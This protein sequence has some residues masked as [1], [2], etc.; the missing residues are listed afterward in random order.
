MVGAL[1]VYSPVLAAG[2]CAL[3]FLFCLVATKPQIAPWLGAAAGGVYFGF[4]LNIQADAGSLPISPLDAVPALLLFSALRLRTSREEPRQ[5]SATQTW[6]W[7]AFAFLA[8]GLTLGSIIGH[9][10]GTDEYPYL[11]VV[12]IEVSLLVVLLAALYAGRYP[13]WARAVTAGFWF[14]GILAALESLATFGA[15]SVLGR[16]PWDLMGIGPTPLPFEAAV[17][18]DTLGSA[19]DNYLPTFVM[20]PALALCLIRLRRR[21]V[22]LATL[23]LVA[24]ALSLSRAMWFATALTIGLTGLSRLRTHYSLR[25]LVRLATVL[26]LVVAFLWVTI[27]S[28][29]SARTSQTLTPSADPSQLYRTAETKLV[30]DRLLATPSDAVLGLGAGTLVDPPIVANVV[31]IKEPSP[32]PENQILGRWLNFGLLSVIGISVL[33]GGATVA[34]IRLMRRGDGSESLGAMSLCLL[35]L[36]LTGWFGGTVFQLPV[37]LPLVLL[38]GTVLATWDRRGR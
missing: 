17:F 28:V 24:I 21:D 22:I 4:F 9:L 11:R 2:G 10:D 27:G 26:L 25:H 16:S 3:A 18:Q 15:I 37:T 8:A 35:P 38:A 33:F 36:L 20:L 7:A 23:I 6:G 13:S 34:G 30:L 31:V 5:L 14:A 19:R 32:I 29:L 1:V 12:G